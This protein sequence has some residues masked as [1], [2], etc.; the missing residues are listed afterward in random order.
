MAAT[1]L[2]QMARVSLDVGM[3]G[4]V[5]AMGCGRPTR[6]VPPR[7]LRFEGRTFRSFELDAAARVYESECGSREPSPIPFSAPDATPLEKANVDLSDG[8]DRCEASA[9]AAAHLGPGCECWPEGP[10]DLATFWL[11]PVREGWGGTLIAPVR[12]D[13]RSGSIWRCESE[14]CQK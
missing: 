6:A 5:A 9:L 1:E 12:V 7:E 8:V 2:K 14:R 11:V 3:L 10:L 4:L 13:K